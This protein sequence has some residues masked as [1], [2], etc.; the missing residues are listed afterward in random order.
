VEAF[1]THQ[2]GHLG[3][4]TFDRRRR[5]IQPYSVAPWVEE[6]SGDPLIPLLQVLRGDFFCLPF[7]GNAASFRGEKHPPHGQ[8]ANAKWK[9]EA[10]ERTAASHSLHLSLATTARPGR[11]DKKITLV[12]G[13][14][15]IYCQHIISGMSGPVNLGHHAMLRF[16][17]EPGSG[18]ISTSRFIY[19]QVCPQPFES[20]A[21]K[22]YHSLK[23]GAEFDALEQV[24]TLNGEVAD[25]SRYPARRGF[26]D[27]V[28]L[29]GDEGLPFAWTAVV[30]PRQQYVWFALRNPRLLRSTIFWISNGGRHYAPWNGRHV[31]VMGLED[32]TSYFHFGLAES[33][34]PNPLSQRGY[35]TVLRLD[36]KQPLTVPYLMGVAL[37]P[38]GF[39]RVQ[40]IEAA[41]DKQSVAIYS[42][43]GKKV[44]ASIAVDFL[45]R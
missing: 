8:T 10:W 5:K 20:P 45:D 31:N 25:L 30:F 44:K 43:N 3:P 35:P 6:K 40:R 19:G 28:L 41:P 29:V 18:L 21:N 14:N 23:T 17:D 1:I 39:N 13:H 16:P 34:R 7:G 27:L 38:Q 33:A 4:V 11:V 15:A 26:E 42:V 2:G 12:D 9:F 37:L 32:V 24:P 22:G 36:K